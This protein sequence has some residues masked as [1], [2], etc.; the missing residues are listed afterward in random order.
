MGISDGTTREHL[1][2]GTITQEIWQHVT[3]VYD[4]NSLKLY[5]NGN[6]EEN[7]TVSTLVGENANNLLLGNALQTDTD[8][9]GY[10]DEFRISKTN[11]SENWIKTEFLNQ[12][13]PYTFYSFEL[14]EYQ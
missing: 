12:S 3:G 8:F 13:N 14:K 11:R 6:L 2:G 5:I 10:L 9:I 4:G 1:V 7:E